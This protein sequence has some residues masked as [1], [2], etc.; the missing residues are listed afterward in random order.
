MIPARLESVNGAFAVALL[1]VLI[2]LAL[3]VQAAH[4]NLDADNVSELLGQEIR[5]RVAHFPRRVLVGLVLSGQSGDNAPNKLLVVAHVDRSVSMDHLVIPGWHAAMGLELTGIPAWRDVPVDTAEHDENGLAFANFPPD[6][7]GTS[8]MRNQRAMLAEISVQQERQMVRFETGVGVPDKRT[9]GVVP[10]DAMNL[11]DS[12]L[13]KWLGKVHAV[14]HPGSRAIV[15]R[16]HTLRHNRLCKNSQFEAIRLGQFDMTRTINHRAPC[17]SRVLYEEMRARIADGIYPSGTVLPSTR[18]LAEERGLSRGTVSLVY[19][20]LAA[21]GFIESRPGAAS[22]VSTGGASYSANLLKPPSRNERDTAVYPSGRL[23]AVGQRIVAL[24]IGDAGPTTRGEI[25]FIYGPLAGGDFPTLAWMRAL[26]ATER[27]RVRRLDYEDPR[28][29]LNLRRA[30]QAHLSQTRGLACALEQILVVNGSQQALDL[31]ARL[32]LDPGDRVV[33]ENPGYRMAHHAFEAC[34]AKLLCIEVDGHGLRTDLLG[35]VGAAQVAYVTPTHQFPLGAFLPIGRRRALLDWAAKHGAWVIEDDYDSEYRYS[36]RPEVT[37]QALD[38]HDRV[39]HVGTF[40]KTLSPQLRLGYMV[41]PLQLVDVF[42]AAKR[43]SDRHAPTGIQRALAF[44]LQEGSYDRHVRR[45]RRIQQSRQRALLGALA[46]H[47][48]SRIR[49]EG[50]ASGLHL[51][52]WFSMLPASQE[53]ALVRAVRERGVRV[54]PIGPLFHP[55][56]AT[57][58]PGRRAG[59]VM[60]YASLEVDAI[61]T[62]IARLAAAISSLEV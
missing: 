7:V 61:E 27:Q 33:V 40:S 15:A 5:R 13:G 3:A 4:A 14:S 52:L 34:G 43:V 53:P 8:D 55:S 60:G 44:L 30:L 49:I 32:L 21:D 12:G 35:K 56:A 45:M 26:R 51:V 50:A 1:V 28:G 57:K 39:I 19:E 25:D 54:C 31:C 11:L 16:T 9:Q 2:Q 20:Q 18:A 22:R 10:D 38:N 37:L 47:F 62:G 23:S 48:G 6:P 17:L 36:V 58:P 24:R 29:N 46:K 42:T 41:V 59:L